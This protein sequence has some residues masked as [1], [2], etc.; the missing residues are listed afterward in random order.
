MNSIL[1]ESIFTAYGTVRTDLN[2]KD[3]A[4]LKPLQRETLMTVIATNVA[5]VDADAAVVAA[6]K[7]IRES[8]HAEAESVK[9]HARIVP[10]WTAH[11]E[12]KK[13]VARLPVPP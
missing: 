13:T 6:D 8:V 11:D 7:A 10:K 9:D 2:K 1:T 12:W 5:A 4:A 3:I